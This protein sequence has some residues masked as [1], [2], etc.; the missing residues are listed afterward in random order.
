MWLVF[1]AQFRKIKSTKPDENAESVSSSRAHLR[2]FGGQLGEDGGLRDEDRE[3]RGD[4]AR[5]P[6][7]ED[8]GVHHEGPADSEIRWVGGRNQEMASVLP[9]MY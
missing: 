9:L 2:A 3:P 1:D 8:Q 7:G 6:H 5:S 4:A